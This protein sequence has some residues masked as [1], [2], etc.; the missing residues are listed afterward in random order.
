MKRFIL[1]NL[2][3]LLL[4]SIVTKPSFAEEKITN[5]IQ[6]IVVNPDGS[7]DITE[8]ITVN[9][10]ANKIKRGIYRDLINIGK[11]NSIYKNKANLEII[12]IKKDDI[13]E[14][15]HTENINGNL[16]LYIGD[17]SSY[18]T[19]GI[20]E[21]EIN[22][23]TENQIR[24]FKEYDELYYNITGNDWDFKIDKATAKITLPKEAKILNKYAYTGYFGEKGQDFSID[25]LQDNYLEISTTKPLLPK[26]GISVA[27]SFNKGIIQKPLIK[28]IIKDFI[29]NSKFFILS[30]IIFI[31]M[32]YYLF[33]SWNKYCKDPRK[34]VY[35]RYSPPEGISACEIGHIINKGTLPKDFAACIVEMANKGFLIIKEHKKRLFYLAKGDLSKDNLNNATDIEISMLKQIFGDD[36][37]NDID[38]NVT[39][40]GMGNLLIYSQKLRIS[41]ASKELSKILSKKFKNVVYTKNNKYISKGCILGIISFLFFMMHIISLDATNV[42]AGVFISIFCIIP[43][44]M[45][46]AILS[47]IISNKKI[48]SIPILIV[49]SMFLAI[50]CITAFQINQLPILIFE[51]I[52]TTIIFIFYLDSG[53]YTSEG[54]DIINHIEG[55]KKYLRLAE[56]DRLEFFTNNRLNEDTFEKFLP[57]AIALKVEN[58]WAKGF[59]AYLSSYSTK[60]NNTNNPSW[61][62]SSYSNSLNSRLLVK[63]LSAGLSS[64]QI[65]SSSSSS[66][67]SS[68]SGSSGG[69]FSGGGSGGGGGGGW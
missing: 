12:S 32:I 64:I 2:F 39:N 40:A 31:V 29:I 13:D 65:G 42:V 57:Y 63:N 47:S 61:Y 69:G 23:R 26:E 50:A 36:L 44:M 55:F 38:K 18:L 37:Q 15:F 20:Y 19:P 56:K 11:F 66:T 51:S 62:V 22:Y 9:S 59:D 53:T 41:L 33:Y 54:M 43:I 17:K 16:R 60:T 30:M 48:S 28:D 35:T 3:I 25:K 45:F 58:S 49:P 21:Y 4:I 8:T 52:L 1:I 14:P 34:E 5:Y 67:S 24:F 7:L 46:L 68:S 6:E 10:E 27:A